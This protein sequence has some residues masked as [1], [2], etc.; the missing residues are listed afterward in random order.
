MNSSKTVTADPV[1]IPKIAKT[2][3]KILGAISAAHLLNDMI[4][5]LLLAL[6]P[7]LQPEFSLSF[8]QIGLITLTFQVT[9]SLLQPLIGIY[10]D[11]Y[12]QPRSLPV[13]MGFTLVGLIMLSLAQ[14]YPEIL[15]AAALVG[16]GSSVFHPESSRVARMASGGR[17]GLA[18]SLFQVG[19]NLGSA[20]GPLLAAIIIAP[21]GKGHVA[22]FV[23]AALLAMIILMQVSRWYR[24]QTKNTGPANAAR[25]ISPFPTK[26]VI[27]GISVLLILIFSKFVYMSSLSSYYTFYLINKFNLPVQK[28]QLYLFGFLFAAAAG[29]VIGGPLGDR[30][31][32]KKVI[33]CSILGA[34]PFS[35]FL[36]YLNLEMTCLFTIIIGLVLSSAFS[37]ILVFAQE[38]VPG[39]IGMISGLFFG[40]AFGMGGLG[41]AGLGIIADHSGI[42]TVFQLCSFLPLIGLMTVFLPK[43]E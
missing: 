24:V 11:K 2:S 3:F 34:A 21:Y 22:W 13:G 9:S 40:F 23:L 4:Q 38:L 32:R 25:E 43:K 18:Q 37:A 42:D 12:P 16:T 7:L 29:T 33:W 10:T 39:R 26:T 36:P 19:G 14:T 30:F 28:A 20:L 6:Y 8:V 5:S 31:G 27:T 35:L 41:A 17:H 15:I 1:H